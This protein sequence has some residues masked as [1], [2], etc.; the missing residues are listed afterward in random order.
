MP[1]LFCIQSSCDYC[2]VFVR[3]YNVSF[4]LHF[5]C[6]YNTVILKMD[7]F[8]RLMFVLTKKEDGKVFNSALGMVKSY[9]VVWH[10]TI[11]TI[12]LYFY[13]TI[14]FLYLT[15]FTW[16][17][18]LMPLHVAFNFSS[19]VFSHSKTVPLDSWIDPLHGITFFVSSSTGFV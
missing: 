14:L 16:Y 1:L 4:L 8:V 7:I 12:L 10:F 17:N 5:K 11:F 19:N 6:M 3:F 13:Y 2:H 9:N 18:K 15:V